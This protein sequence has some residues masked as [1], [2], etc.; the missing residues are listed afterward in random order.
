MVTLA[1]V[2]KTCFLKRGAA[3]RPLFYMVLQQIP[4]NLW[5]ADVAGQIR[6]P[7]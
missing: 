3:K 4:K 1:V 6:K 5:D 7:K 2:I